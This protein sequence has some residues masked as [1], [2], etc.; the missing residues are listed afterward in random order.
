MKVLNGGKLLVFHKYN[1]L[2]GKGHNTSTEE[3]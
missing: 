2:G 1:D 3:S